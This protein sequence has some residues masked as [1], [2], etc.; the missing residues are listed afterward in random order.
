MIPRT[1]LLS[2]LALT[3]LLTACSRHKSGDAGDT[4]VQA[5]NAPQVEA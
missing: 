4:Q 1:A 2:T 3:L 5:D